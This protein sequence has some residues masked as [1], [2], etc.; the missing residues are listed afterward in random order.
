MLSNEELKLIDYFISK[1]E[2]VMKF[3]EMQAVVKMQY[4]IYRLLLTP[5]YIISTNLK[6]E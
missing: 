1:N 5:K 3:E 6:G 4:D 2:P